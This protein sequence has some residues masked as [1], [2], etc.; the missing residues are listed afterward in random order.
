MLQSPKLENLDHLALDRVLDQDELEAAMRQLK[1]NKSPGSD[2]LPV[3]FYKW[4]WNLIGAL[5]Y[6]V[7]QEA[8]I[9]KLHLSAR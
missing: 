8:F 3:E 1:S 5:L 4:F 6:Q 2:G 9:D 7:Y